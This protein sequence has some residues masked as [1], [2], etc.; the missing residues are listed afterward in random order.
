MATFTR[1]QVLTLLQ[2]CG[3]KSGDTL[4]VHSALLSFGLPSDPLFDLDGYWYDILR[5]AVGPTGTLVFPAFSYSYCKKQSFDVL[6]TMST[7][8]SLS[9]YLLRDNLALR[10]QDV[11]GKESQSKAPAYTSSIRSG[12]TALYRTLDPIFS[13][14]IDAPQAPTQLFS[15]VCFDYGANSICDFLLQQKARYLMLGPWLYF[16]LMHC[17]EQDMQTPNRFLKPFA[18]TMVI[19]DSAYHSTQY[20]YCRYN[21]PATTILTN[22]VDDLVD[23]EVAEGIASLQPLGN[24]RVLSVL[25]QDHLD[26]Y[27]KQLQAA[28]WFLLQGP[29]QTREQMEAQAPD[30]YHQEVRRECYPAIALR[31]L[32]PATE[33]SLPAKAE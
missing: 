21:V 5:T 4:L 28:P 17:V 6:K 22:K 7:V 12:K 19:G 29:A 11:S 23:A 9:N 1:E 25:V 31:T 15:N 33:G 8:S 3:V 24:N 27:R 20:F 2:E 10:E 14:I 32:K 13:Y 26:F 16:T 18:G 30:L